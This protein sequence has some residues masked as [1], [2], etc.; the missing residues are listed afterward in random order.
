[1]EKA[2]LNSLVNPVSDTV[3]VSLS[4]SPSPRKEALPHEQTHTGYPVTDVSVTDYGFLGHFRS[5]EFRSSEDAPVM[6]G[7]AAA[8]CAYV[9]ID[10]AKFA[11]DNAVIEVEISAGGMQ[12][13][14]ARFTYS[15]GTPGN[16]VIKLNAEGLIEMIY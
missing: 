14:T 2:L 16:A 1:M 8:C 5:I 15:S 13:G 3:E 11:P 10:L 9:P 12:K 6:I 4:W 7:G